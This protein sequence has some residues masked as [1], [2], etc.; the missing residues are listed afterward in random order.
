[1]FQ[2]NCFNHVDFFKHYH[3]KFTQENAK[4]VECFKA[5]CVD[6]LKLR[7]MADLPNKSPHVRAML[8]KH[9]K[10]IMVAQIL[11]SGMSEESKFNAIRWFGLTAYALAQAPIQPVQ[12]NNTAVE[13]TSCSGM[14][15][16][17]S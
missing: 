2:E 12:Q 7:V 10:K 9:L 4:D 13:I 17:I 1:M 15:C 5:L 11:D 6:I 16:I 3:A 8:G 14:K